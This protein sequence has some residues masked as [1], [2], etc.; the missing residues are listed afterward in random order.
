MLIT[1]DPQSFAPE[2]LGRDAE[3]L[4]R[5]IAHSLIY[6]VSK[7]PIAARDRAQPLSRPASA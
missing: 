6:D 2:Q 5:A 4:Q 3:S 7:D 1:T